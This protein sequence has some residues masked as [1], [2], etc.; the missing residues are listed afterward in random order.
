M[1][2]AHI[3]TLIRLG[4]KPGIS[5]G[6]E[7]IISRRLCRVFTQ[8]RK[9]VNSERRAIN[10][11]ARKLRAYLPFT[12]GAIAELEQSAANHQTQLLESARAALVSFGLFILQDRKG[13]AQA[14]GF[15]RLCNVLGINAVHR[16]QIDDESRASLF[17][18]I[19]VEDLEDSVN[20]RSEEWGA[21]GPLYEACLLTMINFIK[22]CPESLLPN[23]FA[24]GGIFGPKPPPD[25]RLV[26][27]TTLPTPQPASL[28]QSEK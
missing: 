7:L 16:Q 11:Q 18:L 28:A 8:A 22:T 14:L 21:G 5:P 1:N 27:N 12:A 4:E 23:P 20:R 10:R 15:E 17:G 26:C 3:Q 13:I 9:T 25:L 19:Y 24:P 6:D 2:P